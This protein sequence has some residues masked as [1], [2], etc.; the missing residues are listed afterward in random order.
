[1]ASSTTKK[2]QIARFDRDPLAG[3]VNPATYQNP[4]G[5]ELL[6]VNGN[7]IEVPYAD[8]K[9]VHFV[10]DFQDGQIRLERSAFFT[11]PKLDGLWVRMTFRDDDII[12]AVLPN[13]LLHPEPFGFTVTPPD[14]AGNTQRMFVP[15]AALKELVVLGVVGSPRNRAKR[16]PA[17]KDQIKL[18]E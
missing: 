5:I 15:K 9:A 11:R 13:T 1:M 7:A 4:S 16:K 6:S 3:F 2:V 17:D 14:S 18:F 8:V 12:E 10:R